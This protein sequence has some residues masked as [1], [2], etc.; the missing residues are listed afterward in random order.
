MGKRVGIDEPWD[1][2]I[3]EQVRT[4]A[5]SISQLWRHIRESEST[6]ISFLQRT[7]EG[8]SSGTESIE[9]GDG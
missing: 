9:T 1:Y 6:G 3:D 2:G 4:P 8:K 7:R 5:L